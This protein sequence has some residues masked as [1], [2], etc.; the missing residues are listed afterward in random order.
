MDL[1][2]LLVFARVVQTGS[3]TAAGAALRMPKSTVSRK[4]TEL[5]AR[6]GAQLLQRTTRKLRLTDVGRAYF[7]HAERVV[8]EAEKAEAVVTGMQSVPHGL[9]RVSA[10][11]NFGFLGPSVAEYL[12]RYPEVQIELLCT[13]RQV[14]LVEEGFDL[15]VR[16]GLLA[17][18]TL[19]AR[20]LGNIGRVV[21]ASPDYL[22]QYGTPLSPADLERH[23]CLVFGA[24]REKN[25]WRLQSG[26][27]SVQVPV[28][29]QLVVN[30]FD[31][32]HSAVLGG[33]GI[34]ML[35]DHLVTGDVAA[36]RLQR[37][38]PE[39]RSPGTPV[40]ALF[41]PGRHI[42]PRARAFV[43]VL[44]ELWRQGNRRD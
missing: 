12:R 35:D 30:D 20:K 21:V 2:E 5:E 33:A 13:D 26:S 29:A 41:P 3:F 22:G 4:I 32:L 42:P 27:R 38:I 36:G 24:T 15:A 40:N 37:L 25:V 19:I 10:P 6:V 16:A 8:A 7:E 18:S 9:L 43:D 28:Y 34:A 14:D 17:E 11:V 1:N 23:A 31:L 44:R 39:W